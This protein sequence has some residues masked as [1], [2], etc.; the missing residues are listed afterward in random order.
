M[1]DNAAQ[2]SARSYLLPVE[3]TAFLLRDEMRAT[4]FALEYAKAELNLRDWGIKSTVVV[5]GSARIPSSEQAEAILAAAVGP[6]ALARAKIR[7]GQSRW[8]EAARAF[9]AL[10]SRRGG[11]TNAA[12]QSRDNVIATGGGPG[13][14]GGG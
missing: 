12:T 9:A 1:S 14:Y 3:D 2:K 6:D 5:F 10:V 7:A 11:A 4:R 13:H 8:Y